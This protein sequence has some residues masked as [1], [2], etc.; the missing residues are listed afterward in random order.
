L[1]LQ[2]EQAKEIVVRVKAEEKESIPRPE[3]PM[4]YAPVS[5]SQLRRRDI[6]ATEAKSPYKPKP[7]RGSNS[8]EQV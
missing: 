1:L 3:K 5:S 8:S 4:R 2:D 6:L 7:V